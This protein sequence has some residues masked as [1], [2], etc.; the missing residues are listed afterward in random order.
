MAVDGKAVMA[1]E[2][3]DLGKKSKEFGDFLDARVTAQKSKQTTKHEIKRIY[4][5]II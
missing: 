4:A 3:F 2:N 1:F 5:F